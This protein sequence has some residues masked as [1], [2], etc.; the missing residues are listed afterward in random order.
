MKILNSVYLIGSSPPPPMYITISNCKLRRNHHP[1]H[2][3]DT[4]LHCKLFNRSLITE[5]SCLIFISLITTCQFL[6]FKKGNDTYFQ[7]LLKNYKRFCTNF[8]N[9][10][11]NDFLP[12]HRPPPFLS[13][14]YMH[15]ILNTW[16]KRVSARPPSLTLN[17]Y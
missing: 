8:G 14:L 3:H 15:L 2:P 11:E 9:F 17:I 1:P 10:L 6:T 12:S 4:Y 7:V 16:I 13:I 5:D